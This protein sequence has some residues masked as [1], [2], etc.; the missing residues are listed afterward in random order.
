MSAHGHQTTIT[1]L[2]SETVFLQQSLTGCVSYVPKRQ[3]G[4]QDQSFMRNWKL[5][6]YG[7]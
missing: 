4:W 6:K 3:H 7:E 1:T 5:E 2:Q